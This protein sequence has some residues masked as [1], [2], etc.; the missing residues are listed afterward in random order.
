MQTTRINRGPFRVTNRSIRVKLKHGP[1]TLTC[2]IQTGVT[3]M[4][5]AYRTRPEWWI[6]RDNDCVTSG[7]LSA[8]AIRQF[9]ASTN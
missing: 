9:Y 3:P 2:K 7:P 8:D 4:G 6:K 5:R 1:A